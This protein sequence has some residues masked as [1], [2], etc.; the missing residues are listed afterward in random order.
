MQLFTTNAKEGGRLL[1]HVSPAEAGPEDFRKVS[2]NRLFPPDPDERLPAEVHI[3]YDKYTRGYNYGY[4]GG[5]LGRALIEPENGGVITIYTRGLPCVV[6]PEAIVAR[7]E[8]FQFPGGI[9]I[10]V[11][12]VESSA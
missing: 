2:I 7:G 12:S 8:G 1:V 6:P 10:D 11:V 4:P 5:H 9:G 3:C